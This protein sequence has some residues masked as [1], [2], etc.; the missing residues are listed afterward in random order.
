MLT[1]LG[2]IAIGYAAL[3][4]LLALL[5]RILPSVLAVALVRAFRIVVPAVGSALAGVSLAVAACDDSS[6][7]YSVLLGVVACALFVGVL[8]LGAVTRYREE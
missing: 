8:C 1:L 7:G 3:T 6:V 4:G 2:G 5:C